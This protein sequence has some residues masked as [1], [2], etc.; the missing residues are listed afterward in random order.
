MKPH[1]AANQICK[2]R[3]GGGD[4][5]CNEQRASDEYRL[6]QDGIERIRRRERRVI[7]KALA[8]KGAHAHRD[9][10]ETRASGGC[11]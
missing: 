4:E 9:R 5:Q 10:R 7:A 8:Q 3:R 6:D 1:A 11:A 2:S